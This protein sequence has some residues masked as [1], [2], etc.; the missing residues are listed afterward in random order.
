MSL[1]NSD[2][3]MLTKGVKMS[4]LHL[5]ALKAMLDQ[6]KLDGIEKYTT[7]GLVT[8][9]HNQVL[10]VK[11]RPDDFMPS[12]Y[13]LPGGTLEG[14]ESIVDCLVRELEEETG[15]RFSSVEDLLPTFDYRSG[16][17]R[18]TRQF[19]F[20]LIV[21]DNFTITLSGEHV[22]YK[23]VSSIEEIPDPG[24]TSEIEILIKI[25]LDRVRSNR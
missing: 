21:P 11:R 18:K 6:A 10:V 2:N 22:A 3:L 4:E 20:V 17:G 9:L 8:N 23:W 19:G 15:I 5:D 12:I 25:Y 1:A 14:D 7:G 13:E 24:V 16:S